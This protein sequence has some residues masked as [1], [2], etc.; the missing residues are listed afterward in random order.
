MKDT[1]C[2]SL[3]TDI[4]LQ[5]LPALTYRLIGGVLDLYVFLGPTPNDVVRQYTEVVGKPFLPPYWSLGY[6]QCRFGYGSTERTREVWQRTREAG[7]PFVSV[8]GLHR[9]T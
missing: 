6:H 1:G 2:I 9:F 5:P 8:G 7:I 3:L 4:V